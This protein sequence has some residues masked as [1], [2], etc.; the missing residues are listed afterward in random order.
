MFCSVLTCVA[1]WFVVCVPH[2]DD[3]LWRACVKGSERDRV[4]QR[5]N[6]KEREREIKR[7]GAKVGVRKCER[8]A[9]MIPLCVY[10]HVFIY[11]WINKCVNM[12]VYMCTYMYTNVETHEYIYTC[13]YIFT[14]I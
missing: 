6:A 4:K 11:I 3:V 1:E 9:E 7:E 14:I 13:V 2:V 10:T 8:E 12:Y 5:K